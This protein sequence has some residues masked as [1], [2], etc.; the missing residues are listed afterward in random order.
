MRPYFDTKAKPWLV[1]V[2]FALIGL[3][4]AALSEALRKG[5][6]RAIEAERAKD[7]LYRELRHRTRRMTGTY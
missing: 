6:E 3:A 7:L 5:W 2:G 1:L 4:L